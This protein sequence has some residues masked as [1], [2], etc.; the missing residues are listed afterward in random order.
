MVEAL[1]ALPPDLADHV[2]DWIT[3]LRDLG[4]G[5]SVNWSDTWTDEDLADARCASL[6][7][8][9]EREHTEP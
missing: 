9:D 5:K 3:Q 1:R 2:I 6:S 4:A 7:A 8:F